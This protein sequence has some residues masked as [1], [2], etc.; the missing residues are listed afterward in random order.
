MRKFKV[1]CYID[2]NGKKYFKVRFKRDFWWY[3]ECLCSDNLSPEE[4]LEGKE[5]DSLESVELKIRQIEENEREN[6]RIQ[7]AC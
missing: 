2:G 6:V 3:V 4:I 1:V 7:V 5:F